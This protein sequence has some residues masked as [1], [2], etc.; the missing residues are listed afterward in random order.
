MSVAGEMVHRVVTRQ[1]RSALGRLW[2]Q[3][4]S[5]SHTAVMR[6]LA[7][8]EVSL[9]GNARALVGS[10]LGKAIDDADMVIR[11]NRAPLLHT[12][13]AGHRLDWLVT[14]VDPADLDAGMYLWMTRRL[15]LLPY[16]IAA[17]GRFYFFPHTYYR[18]LRA[19]LGA[20]PSTGAMAID[21]V[22]RS[23]AASLALYG[24][25]FFASRS[26]SS[27]LTAE[28]APHDFAAEAE[29]VRDLARSDRRVRLVP[30]PAARPPAP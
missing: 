25:D 24:F 4:L 23:D 9:V 2:V 17:S 1:P 18:V 7:G 14:S 20:K 27:N 10:G 21:L 15:D 26:L 29:W 3:H 8:Q 6:D 22:T 19:R 28:A 30:L 11:I 5:R 16:R 13:D 12:P